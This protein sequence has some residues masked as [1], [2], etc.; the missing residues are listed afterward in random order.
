MPRGKGVQNLGV[1]REVFGLLAMREGKARY[2]K[3]C[4]FHG[5]QHRL[6]IERPHGILAHDQS[7]ARAAD[8][9]DF[10]ARTG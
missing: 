10:F 9:F 3:A 2:V 1:D 5:L 4:V 6:A 7:L 8:L